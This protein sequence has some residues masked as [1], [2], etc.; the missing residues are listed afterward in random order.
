MRNPSNLDITTTNGELFTG[1]QS[2][3]LAWMIYLR[4]GRDAGAAHS[5]WKRLLQNSCDFYSFNKL[6]EVGAGLH[7]HD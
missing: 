1:M 5:A 6:L 7:T 2:A 4:F 3:E